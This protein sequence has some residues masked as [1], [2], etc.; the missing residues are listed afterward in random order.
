MPSSLTKMQNETRTA[1]LDGKGWSMT[2]S[3]NSVGEFNRVCQ[4]KKIL[5]VLEINVTKKLHFKPKCYAH[6]KYILKYIMAK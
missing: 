5:Q 4:K 1:L 2:S 6:F 3:F